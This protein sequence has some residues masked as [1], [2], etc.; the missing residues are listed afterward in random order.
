MQTVQIDF[1][2]AIYRATGIRA[3][4]GA[5]REVQFEPEPGV[6]YTL[7]ATKIHVGGRETFYI[8]LKNAYGAAVEDL[9]VKLA[10]SVLKIDSKKSQDAVV[11][12]GKDEEDLRDLELLSPSRTIHLRLHITLEKPLSPEATAKRRKKQEQKAQ[13]TE[14]KRE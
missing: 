12:E 13:H 5:M 6:T 10:G 3:E 1:N 7:Q 14:K 2:D 8:G 4:S 9:Q 11:I